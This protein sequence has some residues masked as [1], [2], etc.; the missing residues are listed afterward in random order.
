M[1]LRLAN[2]LSFFLFVL[3]F[4]CRRNGATGL[5]RLTVALADTGPGPARSL[6]QAHEWWRV[7][8]RPRRVLEINKLMAS[9]AHNV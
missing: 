2:F 3:F 6:G 4:C 5:R 9:I 8:A 1:S 7:V